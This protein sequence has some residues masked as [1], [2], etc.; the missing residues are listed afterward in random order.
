MK[1]VKILVCSVFCAQ[2]LG[3]ANI[4]EGTR[5]FLG[6]STKELINKRAQAKKITFNYSYKEC[7]DRALKAIV[8][9][10]AYVYA[11]DD[12][13]NLIAIYVNEA[14]TTAVGIFFKEID[15]NSTQVEVSSSSTYAKE[16][17]AEKLFKGL[18]GTEQKKEDVNEEVKGVETPVTQ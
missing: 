4:K 9:M 6:V 5:G 3:C 18:G 2:L 11:K 7:Y 17:I 12:K 8:D 14:D 1:I 13:E 10:N 16:L 15:A